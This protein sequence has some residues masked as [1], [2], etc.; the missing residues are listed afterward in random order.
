MT[1]IPLSPGTA[2]GYLGGPAVENGGIY[3]NR[4]KLGRRDLQAIGKRRL[5]ETLPGRSLVRLVHA[6]SCC[7][8]EPSAM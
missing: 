2:Y 1:E 6:A 3:H 4:V 7:R 8:G 5:L